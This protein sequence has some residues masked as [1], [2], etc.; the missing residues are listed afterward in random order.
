MLKFFLSHNLFFF[1]FFFYCQ[2]HFLLSAFTLQNL[3]KKLKTFLQELHIVT[4][5]KFQ[6]SNFLFFLSFFVSC[7]FLLLI[8]VFSLG[9]NFVFLFRYNETSAI[10]YKLVKTFINVKFRLNIKPLISFFCFCFA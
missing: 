6:L 9:T 4:N 7:L 3:N 10:T 2:F 8:L 1:Y 5:G